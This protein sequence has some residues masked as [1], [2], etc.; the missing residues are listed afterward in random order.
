[1]S[2]RRAPEL[3]KLAEPCV[4]LHQNCSTPLAHLQENGASVRLGGG[5]GIVMPANGR[6][7]L[8]NAFATLRVLRR[9]LSCRLPVELVYHGDAGM[10]SDLRLLFEVRRAPRQVR[11]LAV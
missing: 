2:T 4:V 3:C 7:Q 9:E 10:P 1:M 5:R 11:L 6:R 8:A